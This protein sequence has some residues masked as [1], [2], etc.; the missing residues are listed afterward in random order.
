MSQQVQDRA[1]DH[2]GTISM[3]KM[4]HLLIVFAALFATDADARGIDC[5]RPV[6]ELDKL[7]C[8]D[9]EM[10]DYD[11]RIAAAYAN[12]LSIWGGAIAPYVRREQQEWLTVFRTIETLESEDV[13]ALSD[14]TCIR[15]ELRRRVVDIE[16]G[17]YVY[18]G[19]YRSGTGM[20]LLLHP[21][22]ANDYRVRIYDPR[23]LASANI[24]TLD[25]ERTALWDGPQTLISVMG[26]GN[27][28][29]L[30]ADDG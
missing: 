6:T 10:L 17:A 20:K 19:V 23:K 26:D 28:L 13:C 3:T 18:S 1:I 21:R 27:G 24:V 25:G 7:V 8:S 4:A 15:V 9:P 30:P 5:S 12:G 14:L 11:R 29:P 16:S 2:D 22:Y